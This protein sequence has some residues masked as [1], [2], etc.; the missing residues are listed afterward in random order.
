MSWR[1]P[2]P[3][4][5]SPKDGNVMA[6]GGL[7]ESWKAPDGSILRTVCIVT[8]GPNAVMAPI[9][10]RM[11]VIV[12]PVHWQDWLFAPVESVQS[13]VVPCSDD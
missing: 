1:T 5:I 4:Y 12:P 6:L 13:L 10:D 2:S 11:P 7:W 8:V 9:Y 3:Y